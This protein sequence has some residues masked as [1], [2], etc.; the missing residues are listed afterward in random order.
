M[1]RSGGPLWLWGESKPIA[2][3]YFALYRAFRNGGDC[4]PTADGNGS[5]L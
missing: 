2:Y 4:L 5:V 3:E 1:V